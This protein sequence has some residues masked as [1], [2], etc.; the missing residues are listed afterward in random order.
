MPSLRQEANPKSW[1]ELNQEQQKAFQSIV[2]M[3]KEAVDSVPLDAPRSGTEHL[4]EPWIRFD[5]KSATAFLSGT[6]GS[7]KTTV[8]TS[9]VAATS[10]SATAFQFGAEGQV[11][12]DLK[13]LHKR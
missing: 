3:I 13:A 9:L 11:A 6:R 8:F 1:R 10:P 12:E 2:T 7:G 5:R 4:E